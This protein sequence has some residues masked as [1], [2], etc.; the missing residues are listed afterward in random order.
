MVSIDL[1]EVRKYEGLVHI[2]KNEIDFVDKVSKAMDEEDRIHENIVIT[3][4]L[5]NRQ[6]GQTKKPGLLYR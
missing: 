2:G 1:P 5:K 4:G 6:K 3:T